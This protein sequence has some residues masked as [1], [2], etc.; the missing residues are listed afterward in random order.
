M[1]AV[2]ERIKSFKALLLLSESTAAVQKALDAKLHYLRDAL[3]KV[4]ASE[5]SA[6]VETGLGGNLH[7][8]QAAAQHLAGLG[9]PVD[10]HGLMEAQTVHAVLHKM[11]QAQNEIGQRQAAPMQRQAAPGLM[12]HST[13]ANA[14]GAAPQGTRRVQ[15]VQMAGGQQGGSIAASRQPR[16]AAT[17]GPPLLP[18]DPAYSLKRPAPHTAGP[19]GKQQRR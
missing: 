9:A 1:Q 4:V 6:Q 14:A 12:A 8:V 16:A 15:H 17:A 11:Q 10:A 2:Q 18:A 19:S 3:Q 5:G 13:A 7:K